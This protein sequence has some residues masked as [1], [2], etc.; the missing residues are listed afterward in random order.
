MPIKDAQ[1][2]LDQPDRV[3]LVLNRNVVFIA[4]SPD[5]V[6]FQKGG[7]DVEGSLVLVDE[8][9][10]KHI[11][12]A[13]LALRQKNKFVAWYDRVARGDN[14]ECLHVRLLCD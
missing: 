2:F 11:E 3:E 13:K 14:E 12:P 7:V 8:Q 9:S 6:E 1:T 10:T 4:K 5:A